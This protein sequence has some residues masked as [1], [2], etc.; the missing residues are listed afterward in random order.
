MN[1][2]IAVIGARLLHLQDYLQ[3]NTKTFLS[4]LYSLFCH[5]SDPLPSLKIEV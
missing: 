1:Y 2:G 4:H 3:T 5:N